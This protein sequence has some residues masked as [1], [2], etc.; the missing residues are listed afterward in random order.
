M[1]DTTNYLQHMTPSEFDWQLSVPFYV[2]HSTKNLFVDEEIDAEALGLM[3]MDQN[4]RD[5]LVNNIEVPHDVATLDRL[6][7]SART[8]Y[9]ENFGVAAPFTP[10]VHI[11]YYLSPPRLERR[12]SAEDFN[13]LVDHEDWESTRLVLN[14]LFNEQV[15]V[16]VPYVMGEGPL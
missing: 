16:V 1:L 12:Q 13:F 6:W 10:T 11:P 8:S 14:D 9:F 5:W 7:I 3:L 15:P 2:S 4:E